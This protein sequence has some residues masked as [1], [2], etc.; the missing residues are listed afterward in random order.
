MAET[1][2]G[3]LMVR[4]SVTG[5][6]LLLGHPGGPFWAKRDDGAWSIPKGMLEP[7]EAPLVAARREFTEE[8][9]LPT[10]EGPFIAL[11]EVRNASGKRVMAWA[12]EGDCD[13]TKLS[14][15]TCTVEWPPRSKHMIEIPEV[16]RYAFFTP[17]QAAIKLFVAQ[18]P[19][20]ERVLA[21]FPITR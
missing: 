11:G 17:G 6:E 1:S 10:P 9:S 19:F 8:T 3:L 12:F 20:L 2:A 18:L 16:D 7:G 13:P 14:S 4:R 21:Q 5:L 15:N